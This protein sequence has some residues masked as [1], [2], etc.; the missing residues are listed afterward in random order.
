MTTL[1]NG[2]PWREPIPA[3]TLVTPAAPIVTWGEAA[4]HLR[5]D[6]E[7]ERTLVETYVEVATQHLD[8]EYGILAGGTLGVQTWD[9]HLDAFP[10]GPILH[11]AVAAHRCAERQLCRRGRVRA[12]YRCV[13]LH[14]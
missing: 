3:L 11:S 5:I 6:D 2:Y 10:C 13:E 7:A 8:A 1:Y 4:S 12:D 9:L 14:G